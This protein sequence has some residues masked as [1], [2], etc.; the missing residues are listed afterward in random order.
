M[1]RKEEGQ[2]KARKRPLSRCRAKH[3][4]IDNNTTLWWDAHAVSLPEFHPRGSFVSLPLFPCVIVLLVKFVCPMQ[5]SL[6]DDGRH[7]CVIKRGVR[8]VH[9]SAQLVSPST[10]GPGASL[11]PLDLTHVIG[12]SSSLDKTAIPLKPSP[13]ILLVYPTLALPKCLV[14]PALDAVF[15]SLWIVPPRG[16]HK[17]GKMLEPFRGEL[18]GADVH[19]SA[20]YTRF[21]ALWIEIAPAKYSVRKALR[22]RQTRTK[23]GLVGKFDR[24]VWPPFAT[25]SFNASGGH[26]IGRIL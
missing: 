4:S 9:T 21:P 10:L 8:F 3:G 6:P 5:E 2:G 12:G 18:F 16:V 14:S 7:A 19:K 25:P 13:R 24:S 23:C 22:R 15:V 20:E 17:F 26:G 1:E 11:P